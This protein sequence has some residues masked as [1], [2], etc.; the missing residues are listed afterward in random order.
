MRP[1]PSCVISFEAAIAAD[2]R[3]LCAGATGDDAI[4]ACSRFLAATGVARA[5]RQRRP[6]DTIIDSSRAGLTRAPGENLTSSQRD[7]L[8]APAD[9]IGAGN[10]E[11]ESLENGGS[12]VEC[13]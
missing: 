7:G 9:L 13:R 10:E 4:N 5:D 6:C 1:F 3:A 12:V 2:D 8:P 11:P